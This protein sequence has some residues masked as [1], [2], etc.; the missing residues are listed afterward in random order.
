MGVRDVCMGFD[1]TIQTKT[2]KCS[3]NSIGEVQIFVESNAKPK[4]SVSFSAWMNNF[5]AL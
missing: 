5:E 1:E 4:K 2:L 3:R